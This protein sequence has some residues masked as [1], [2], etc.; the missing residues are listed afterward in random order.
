MSL[1]AR[2][3]KE[4]RR[5]VALLGG[6]CLFLSTIEYMIP[7]PLPFMR[8]GLANAPL[9]IALDIVS[10]KYFVLLTLIKLFGQAII[11]GTL[12]SYVFLFS[13]VGT[14][15][16]AGFMYLLRRTLSPKRISFIGISLIG[17]FFSNGSQLALARFFIFGEGIRF[18]IPPFLGAGIVTGMT[19]GLFCETFAAGSRWYKARLA[20]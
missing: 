5:T 16:S 18:L 20:L 9:L 14:W 15:V 1:T 17:A 7:K 2:S 19:L 11:T 4:Q 6:F 8:I 10:F 12:F 3:G 13:L